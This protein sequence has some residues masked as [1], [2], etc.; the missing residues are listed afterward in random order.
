M[1]LSCVDAVRASQPVR[2]KRQKTR[3]EPRALIIGPR[4]KSTRGYGRRGLLKA[5][6]GRPLTINSLHK[7]P[8][9][10]LTGGSLPPQ[11]FLARLRNWSI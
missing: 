11:L 7:T 1:H 3:C 10:D 6:A 8:L 2:T 5:D 9:L 4:A